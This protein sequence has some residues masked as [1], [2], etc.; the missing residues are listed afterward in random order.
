MTYDVQKEEIE[1]KEDMQDSF[2]REK[3]SWEMTYNVQGE[4]IEWLAWN[5]MQG[6]HAG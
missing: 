6:R 2:T 5:R 1:C 4:E 3:S